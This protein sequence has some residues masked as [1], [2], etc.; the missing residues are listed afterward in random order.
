MQGFRDRPRLVYKVD[1]ETG[2]ETLVRGVELVGT[3][4][5]SINKIVATGT[6]TGVFN[7]Y[8]GAESGYVPVSTVTPSTLLQEVE[9]QKSS[10][11][12]QRPPI[13]KPPFFE[14]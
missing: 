9:L 13:L 8:C 1:P 3:P 6:E 7:G 11:K 14:P 12:P 5:I 4:L 2:A 10:E